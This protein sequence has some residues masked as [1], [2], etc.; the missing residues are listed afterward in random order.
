MSLL[1]N[2]GSVTNWLSARTDV[3]Q[4]EAATLLWRKFAFRLVRLARRQLRNVDRRIYDEE[5]LALSTLNE[6]CL[7]AS[8]GQYP[9]LSSRKDLWQLLV[10]ISLNKSRNHKRYL[11]R[12]KRSE[13]HRSNVHDSSRNLASTIDVEKLL[14]ESMYSPDCIAMMADECTH[15]LKL[16]DHHDPT[17]KLRNIA[18]MRLDG[19]SVS[20]IASTL[21]CTRRTTSIRLELIQ[22]IWSNHV[23][24]G[25]G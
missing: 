10:T 11:Y 23:M 22:A 1:S 20:R 15:L 3:D 5:D 19:A 7:R 4:D 25:L 24:Q 9:A 14:D 17:G 16:L 13:N 2:P 18:F 21:G 6:F 8:D 12:L